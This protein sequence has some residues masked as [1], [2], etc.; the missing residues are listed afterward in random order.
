MSTANE[1]TLCVI[2][3]FFMYAF[4]YVALLVIFRCNYKF[5]VSNDL[6]FFMHFCMIVRIMIQFIFTKNRN[7][8]DYLSIFLLERLIKMENEKNIEI[9]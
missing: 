8:G 5:Y 4:G 7:R 2:Q 9:I 6:I 1:N 3:K